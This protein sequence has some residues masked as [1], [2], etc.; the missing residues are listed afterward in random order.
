MRIA[1]I[2]PPFIEIPPR[3][4][5]GTELFIANLA[6]ELHRRGHDVTVYGN[7]DSS[8]PCRVK[9]RYEH[10]EWPCDPALRSYLINSD[11]TAWAIRDA[12]RYADVIH[13]NDAVGLPFTAFVDV[14]T[15]L[16]IHHPHDPDLTEQYMRYPR[17]HYIAIAAWLARTEPMPHLHVVH[18]GIPVEAYTFSNDKD[19]YVAFLG[20]MAPCKGA[21]L[22]IEAA[23]R[24]RVRL[25]LAGE[26]QPLFQDYWEER[27][28]P[29]VDGDRVQY[30]GE[31]DFAAKTTLLSKA[32]ALLFPI[33]WDEP[34]GL[35]MI[36]AMA[37]G[38]PVLA[39]PGG[40]VQEIVR[41]GLNGWICRDVDDMARRIAAAAVEPSACRTSVDASFSA[42]RMTDRYI[43]AYRC[44]IS[45]SRPVAPL[46]A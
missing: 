24:A 5:G 32:R 4:Y 28:R 9:W 40:A 18:H 15:V 23:H 16:T 13:L 38:T 35:V 2:G 33:Q 12:S 19:E 46:E 26:V 21:H 20:R 6:R 39:F 27:V 31:A 34:F 37:C 29:F 41:D 7:G 22:A 25:K 36:E 45:R 10:A 17:T 3:R 42:E 44:A 11:H 8:L 14:P 30:L 1:L 43:E